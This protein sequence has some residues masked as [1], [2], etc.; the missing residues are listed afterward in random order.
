MSEWCGLREK[1][2][3][4]VGQLPGVLLPVTPLGVAA[5]KNIS[6]SFLQF[7]MLL[8]S[9]KPT[10]TFPDLCSPSPSLQFPVLGPTHLPVHR[11]V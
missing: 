5:S 3:C 4:M 1:V 10:V 11:T 6:D 9:G 2:V 7:H 8:I